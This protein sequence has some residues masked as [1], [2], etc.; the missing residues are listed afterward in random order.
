MFWSPEVEDAC[1]VVGSLGVGC[2]EDV[3]CVASFAVVDGLIS[4]AMW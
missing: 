4:T 2:V 1:N 3:D